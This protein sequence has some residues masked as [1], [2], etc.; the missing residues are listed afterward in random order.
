MPVNLN[1]LPPE[2]S[3][4]KNLGS[5]LKTFRAL[6]VIAVG[7]FLVFG[8][9]IAA[10]FIIDT[11]SLGSINAKVS[12][13][14]SQV[15]AQEK[16]EQQVVLLKDRLENITS[17]QNMPNSLASLA[18]IEPFLSGFSSNVSVSE[19]QISPTEVDLTLR[20]KSNSDFS[21]LL[22]SIRNLGDFRS[23]NL[24]SFSFNPSSGYSV[25]LAMI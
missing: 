22:T 20:I 4:S 11:M 21:A 14:K 10:L 19:M 8:V 18:V 16:S 7:A 25:E 17:I 2:L 23:V 5:L 13:L 3:I 9:G 24:T 15:T 6:G 1:L 12:A